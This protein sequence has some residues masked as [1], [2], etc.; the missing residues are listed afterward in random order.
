MRSDT[1]EMLRMLEVVECLQAAITK[2]TD[3]PCV[4]VVSLA[5]LFLHTGVII[6]IFIIII[7]IQSITRLLVGD[8]TILQ[9][10]ALKLP[11]K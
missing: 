3:T 2:V 8:F 7:I 9:L 1:I 11:L 5:A 6:M 10:Q 4:G